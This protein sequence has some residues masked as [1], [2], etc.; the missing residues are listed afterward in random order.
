MGQEIRISLIEYQV[1]IGR[2]DT[3]NAFERKR[4]IG[5]FDIINRYPILKEMSDCLVKRKINQDANIFGELV[6]SQYLSIYAQGI[7]RVF[8]LTSI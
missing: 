5:L 3:P 4:E 7:Y 6:A 2:D 8:E 1:R